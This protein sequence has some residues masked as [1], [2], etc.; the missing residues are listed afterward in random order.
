MN[1]KSSATKKAVSRKPTSKQMAK[2]ITSKHDEI[3]EAVHA[4]LNQ[5]GMPAVCLH[6]IR[7]SVAPEDMSD[8]RC[9]QC[10]ENEH[11]VF[12]TDIGEWVCAPK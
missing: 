12:D 5:H 6:S 2:H 3:A 11:C 10:A 7:L 8:S 4:V 9:P 1:K